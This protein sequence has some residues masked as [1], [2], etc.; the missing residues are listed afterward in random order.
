MNATIIGDEYLVGDDQGEMGELNINHLKS[1]H[2]ATFSLP[3]ICQQSLNI[4]EELFI[5]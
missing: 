2:G 3:V 5:R 4:E 1:R